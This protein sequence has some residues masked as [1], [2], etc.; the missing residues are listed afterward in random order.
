[1]RV[2]AGFGWRKNWKNIKYYYFIVLFVYDRIL[3]L[4]KKF[5]SN[6]NKVVVFI[7]QKPVNKN[8][9]NLKFKYN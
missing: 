5:F 6:I 8:C 1:M 3:Y 4:A 2:K 9:K 7:L